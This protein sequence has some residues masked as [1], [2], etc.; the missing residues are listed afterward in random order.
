MAS[1]KP[2]RPYENKA[3]S[4]N[5]LPDVLMAY[6]WQGRRLRQRI[7]Q[8]GAAQLGRRGFRREPDGKEGACKI[9]IA[10]I[11]HDLAIQIEAYARRHAGPVG[12]GDA[13]AFFDVRE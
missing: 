10:H 13:L 8:Q 3:G 9:A 11:G 12:T 7:L 4:A 2:N 1:G 6:S 5:G